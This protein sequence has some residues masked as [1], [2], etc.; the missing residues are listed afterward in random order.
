MTDKIN[1]VVYVVDE[2][3]SMGP[4]ARDV[5]QVADGQS[6]HL[7]R[8]SKE[9]D[10]ETRVSVYTFSSQVKNRI[11]DKDVLRLPSLAGLYSPYG[12]TALIDATLKALDDLAQTAQ[13]YGDHAFLVFVLTDGEENDSI[14]G[15][16]QLQKRLADLPENWTVAVL[17]PNKYGEHEAK[18]FGFPAQNIAI[19]DPTSSAGVAEAGEVITRAT[20]N[21]MAGRAKGVRGTNTLF[22]TG[23]DAVNAKTV[24]A[25]GLTVLPKS[26]YDVLPVTRDEYI[27]PFVERHGI[28]YDIGSAYYQLSKKETIQR[29]KKIAIREKTDDPLKLNTGKVYTG[30]AARELLGLPDMDVKVAPDDNPGYHIYVQSTS[31]NRKLVPGTTLLYMR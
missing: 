22:S 20:D 29:T 2:S 11:F 28:V 13:M 1:H 27:R 24:R 15:P 7:A 5:V 25:A 31:V 16:S 12:R 19:W 30:D 3:S 17:V 8:R 21:F 4:Y 14:A 26:K 6:K 10:Q 9:L 18:S 23:A